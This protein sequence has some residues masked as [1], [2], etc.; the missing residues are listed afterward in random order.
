MLVHASVNLLAVS[1]QR[2]GGVA[3]AEILVG[4]FGLAMLA[5]TLRQR[6]PSPQ[7]AAL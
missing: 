1:A 2:L 4:V 3:V 7:P 6:P 5:F